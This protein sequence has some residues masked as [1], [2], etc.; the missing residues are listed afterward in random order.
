MAKPERGLG[1]G[2]GAL[3]GNASDMSEFRRPV[4]YI[5]QSV[6]N[7][8]QLKEGD[9]RLINVADIVPNPFQ[10]RLTFD[11]QALD[12]LAASIKALG[13]IQPITVR[14]TDGDKFQIISGERRYR[15]SIAAGMTT[16]PAYV[17]KAGDDATMLEMA[18]VE[19]VQ[20][21]DLDPI[22]T[23]MS[24]Q[25]LIDECNLTQEAMSEKIGKSRVAVTNAI[26]LLRLPAK[27]QYDLKVG[28]ISVGHA[29]VLLSLDDSALQEQLCDEIIREGLSVRALEGRIKSL[30]KGSPSRKP[31]SSPAAAEDFLSDN[32]YA[33]AEIIGKYFSNNVAVKRNASGSGTITVRFS[34]EEQVNAFLAALKASD[35]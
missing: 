27:V 31:S 7:P 34:N 21:A 30:E 26:R 24:Y 14:A 13:L 32:F 5:N 23:A 6:D 4:Q 8:K 22:E 33:V 9:I 3:L 20:R 16:I 29:K 15:A 17:R 10:P 11:Q 1:K 25:R 35:L 18:I 28:N 2:L 12:E 19:N